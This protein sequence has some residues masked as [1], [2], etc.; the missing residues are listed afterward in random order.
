M[1][2]LDWMGKDKVVNHHRYVPF[3]V[4]ERITEK[5][6]LDKEGSDHGNMIIHGDNLEA[7]KS[8]LPQF[9]GRVDVIYIDP[10]YNTGN[11]G[12]VYNDN[13][14]DPRIRKW[15]GEVVGKEGEDFSRHDKWLC[16]MYP[17]L[18]LLRRLLSDKGAIF[19]S[20]DDNEFA[21]LKLVCDEIFGSSCFVADISWQRNY[22]TRNDSKGIP[23]EVEHIL[24]YGK[25]SGWQPKKLPRTV[26]MDAKYKN[27]D[28]DVMPWTSDNPCAPGA[29]THQGM[30]YAI[31]HPF[32]GELLYPSQG[33]CW[34][35]EQGQM[36]EYLRGWCEY[37]LKDIDDAEQR[38]RICGVSTA[39]VRTGVPSIVLSNS[40]V[41]SK[42]AA[43][44]VYKRGQWPRFY[45]TKGGK[46]G[47]RRKTYLEN[48][49]GRLPTN[50]WS[51]EECGHTDEAKKEI[52]AIF[53][54][55]TPFDT[56]KPTRLVE[57]VLQV[58]ASD[59][60]LVLDSFAGSGT[61]AH[62]VLNLNKRD[63]GNRRFILV[64]TMD[65]ADNITAERVRRVIAGYG[66]GAKVVEGTNGG[67]S[68][69]EL[70]LNLFNGKGLN[71]AV[72]IKETMRYVWYTE[73]KC[74]YMDRTDEHPYFMGK[75]GETA[76]YLAYDPASETTLGYDLLSGLPVR[77]K[78]TVIYADRCVLPQETLDA[79]SIRFKQIPRQIAR[80]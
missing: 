77:G 48:V 2:T 49:G 71:P 79:L 78:P 69:F 42:K 29:A 66:T 15:L 63:G 46:G 8:L 18:Q 9:E 53:D 10:P 67:F 80:M 70:G 44:A 68:Y 60:A 25:L 26:K 4:L 27:P 23:A 39:D 5:G 31:Q 58:A 56:P 76:Y 54:G 52:K 41:E 40:L 17:R 75:V 24:V 33:A 74:V 13:V 22:S 72:P 51:Y 14:N 38:A 57:R 20:I 28:N 19:I 1:P 36:L 11:E 34:R 59:D 45:F 35:Y 37:E 62:A 61:T 30:V 64:E 7:L 21:N 43:E 32:T 65:Y 3:R 47:I 73:T 50:F 16:M 55:A 12:W 6:T